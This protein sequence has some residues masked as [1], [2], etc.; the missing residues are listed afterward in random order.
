MNATRVEQYTEQIVEVNADFVSTLAACSE[1]EWRRTTASE[2]WPVGVVAHHIAEVYGTF[3]N[4]FE[5]MA[6]APVDAPE[7]TMEMIDENNAHHAR[8]HADASKPETLDLLDTNATA[9]VDALGKLTDECL[10]DTAF[11]VDGIPLSAAQVVELA[12][13]AHVGEHLESV[14]TTI[15]G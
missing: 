4:V 5:N 10:D 6:T 13:I 3:A 9:L 8:V 15:D 11:V 12:L 14:R 1:Q 7:F 2:G